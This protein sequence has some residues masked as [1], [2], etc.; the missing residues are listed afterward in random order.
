MVDG[1]QSSFAARNSV[2]HWLLGEVPFAIIAVDGWM[3][4]HCEFAPEFHQPS[5]ISPQPKPANH[6]HI[7]MHFAIKSLTLPSVCY[8]AL[9]YNV[10]SSI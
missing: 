5:T 2:N 1:S 7:L 10:F 9:S 6:S 8:N 4:F 3:D